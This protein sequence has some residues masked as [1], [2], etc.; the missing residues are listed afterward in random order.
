[1]KETIM[2]T[3]INVI[4]R[5]GKWPSDWVTGKANLVESLVQCVRGPLL[6]AQFCLA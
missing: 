6:L 1:M 3:E 2:D 5:F 4:Y